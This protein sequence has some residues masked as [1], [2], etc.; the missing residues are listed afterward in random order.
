MEYKDL[1]HGKAASIIILTISVLYG[2]FLTAADTVLS[3]PDHISTGFEYRGTADIRIGDTFGS[4]SLTFGGMAEIRNESRFN[5]GILPNHNWRGFVFIC[6]DYSLSDKKDLLEL[7]YG[8]EHESAHPTMGLNDGNIR[9]YDKIYDSTYRNINLNSLMLRLSSTSGSGYALTLTGDIQFYF[10]SRNTPELPVNNLTWSEGISGGFEFKYPL[11]DKRC[12]F[13]SGF[14]RYIFQSRE[15]TSGNIYYNTTS[16]VTSRYEEYPVIN[17]T[18][19]VSAKTGFIFSSI[20]PGRKV[21]IYCG[22]IYG[23]IY[24]FVDSR[25]KRTVYSCGIEI[26]H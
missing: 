9:A 18:N 7:T 26:F 15:K 6:S 2:T 11:D 8:F 16:G 25:E 12:F 1:M 4:D 14:D 19:T 13:I 21:S 17:N 3:D 5:Q 20:I 24:G 23:G 10:K 22:I